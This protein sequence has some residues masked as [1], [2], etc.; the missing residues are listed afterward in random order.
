MPFNGNYTSSVFVSQDPVAIDSVGADF[1]INEP[2]VMDRNGA[3]RNNPNVENHL[4]EAGLVGSAPSGNVYYNGN[5]EKVTNLGVH[6]HWN[7]AA[8]KKLCF[9]HIRNLHDIKHVNVSF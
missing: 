7:N 4:H 9:G 5:G 8:E 1:L 2:S 3:L 6:E